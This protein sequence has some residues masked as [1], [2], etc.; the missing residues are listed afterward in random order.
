MNLKQQ[1]NKIKLNSS[2]TVDFF[3]EN[4]IFLRDLF[5]GI[6]YNCVFF[7]KFYVRLFVTFLSIGSTS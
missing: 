5:S 6:I 4:T 2:K 1:Q 3:H 7:F